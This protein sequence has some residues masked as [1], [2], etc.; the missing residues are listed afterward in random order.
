MNPVK[1]AEIIWWS[2]GNASAN[3]M[4]IDH[5]LFLNM[6]VK[7]MVFFSKNMRGFDA[8]VYLLVQQ[9]EHFLY[10]LPN[11]KTHKS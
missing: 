9:T 3:I 8:F 2:S 5:K 11:K 10:F 1:R 4:K 7:I 6:N